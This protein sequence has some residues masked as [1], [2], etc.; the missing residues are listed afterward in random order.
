VAYNLVEGVLPGPSGGGAVTAEGPH[1]F[2]EV[3]GDP[4]LVVEEILEP[5]I[6]IP[7]GERHQ[8]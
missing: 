6:V 3:A 7:L 2:I 5:L 4:D 1:H 8:R